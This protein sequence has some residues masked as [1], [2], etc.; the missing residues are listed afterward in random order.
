MTGQQCDVGTGA[1][2][3]KAPVIC[4]SDTCNT[5]SCDAATGACKN[6]VLTCDDGLDCTHDSCVVGIG[7]QNTRDDK[8]CVS[9]N[10]CTDSKCTGTVKG[11]SGC[12]ETKKVNFCSQIINGTNPVCSDQSCK[13][14]EGCISILK[15]CNNTNA[16]KECNTYECSEVVS[17]DKQPAGC[18]KVERECANLGAIV[19]AVVGAGA[20]VGIALGVA[21][22]CLVAIA[23]GTA[24]AAHQYKQETESQV[25]ENPTYKSQTQISAGLG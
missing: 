22:L 3:V 24:A 19:G 25:Y 6:L 17:K 14:F 15:N 4:P 16:K 1:C 23:G 11:T 9:A 18:Q 2:P 5:G 20:A 21:F 12:I 8:F 7:C 10:V 13:D